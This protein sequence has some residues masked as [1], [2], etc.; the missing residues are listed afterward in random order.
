[1]ATN[2]EVNY[3]SNESVFSSVVDS[4]IPVLH[5][6]ARPD[7]FGGFS[8][9]VSLFQSSLNELID[10]SLSK[11][12]LTKVDKGF[13]GFTKLKLGTATN[14]LEYNVEVR[15]ATDEGKTLYEA[16]I[17]GASAFT[18]STIAGVV[19]TAVAAFVGAQGATAIAIGVGGT[20]L[21]S[22]LYEDSLLDKVVKNFLTENIKENTPSFSLE[23]SLANQSFSLDLKGNIP[24]GKLPIEYSGESLELRPGT[25]TVLS[26]SE[27]SA[28]YK[29]EAKDKVIFRGNSRNILADYSEQSLAINTNLKKGTTSFS[30]ASPGAIKDY[31]G[32]AVGAVYG[33]ES[34]DKITGSDFS[35]LLYGNAGR[36]EIV[37]GAGDDSLIGGSSEGG[38]GLYQRDTLTG[39]EGADSFFLGFDTL[40]TPAPN[41]TKTGNL[42]TNGFNEVGDGK[43]GIEPRWM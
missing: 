4:S 22:A 33:T 19:A 5:V 21:L 2:I 24:I 6:T 18:G 15:N 41:L 13:K 30:V 28:G 31:L 39:G 27:E 17:E 8:S 14:I 1:M 16:R 37:G 38:F 42:Y 7:F 34:N 25:Y 11:D 10:T 36:D 32:G 23:D 26:A 29:I 12:A 3:D 40:E 9:F 43:F 20:V 35:D